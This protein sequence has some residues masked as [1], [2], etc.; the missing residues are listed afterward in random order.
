MRFNTIILALGFAGL[1]ATANAQDTVPAKKPGGLNKVAHDISKTSKKAG[2]D[3]KAALKDA[4]SDTHQALKKAGNDTKDEAKRDTHYV[5]PEPGHKPGG[6]NK[7]AREVSKVGKKSGAN[8]KHAV[9][10]TA[11]EAHG[12]VTTAGKA[13]KDTLKKIK[14]PM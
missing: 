11:S 9:K 8:A 12:E 3:A 5:P 7:A 13:A 1:A 10:T 4:S 2:R 6:L 14:P